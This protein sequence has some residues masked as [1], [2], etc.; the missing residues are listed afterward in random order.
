ML[1]FRAGVNEKAIS[2]RLA[3]GRLPNVKRLDREISD[4][5]LAPGSVDFAITALNFH[6]IYNTRGPEASASL[7]VIVIGLAEH[8]VRGVE[9][10]VQP[11]EETY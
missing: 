11:A 10:W 8:F 2:K 3:E 5:G 1:K 9:E 7:L 6:D 4:L